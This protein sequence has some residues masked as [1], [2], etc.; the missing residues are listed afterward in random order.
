MSERMEQSSKVHKAFVIPHQKQLLKH[1]VVNLLRFGVRTRLPRLNSLSTGALEG[2][3][4]LYRKNSFLTVGY[5]CKHS[6]DR[7]FLK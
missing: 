1:A 2:I 4:V 3:V 6:R 7:E 5:F